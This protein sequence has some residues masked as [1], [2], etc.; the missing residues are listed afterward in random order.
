MSDESIAVSVVYGLPERQWLLR[1]RVPD[2]CLV[3]DAVEL[4]GI[5][6]RIPDADIDLKRV[7][8]FG[9]PCAADT[10]LR[11]GDRIELYRALLCD[12]KEVRRQRAD[13]E[14]RAPANP[15]QRRA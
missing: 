8:I 6:E 5:R 13:M 1:L 4:S 11:D 3:A 15:P 12:P 9:K 10:R 14:R 2:G 7:G